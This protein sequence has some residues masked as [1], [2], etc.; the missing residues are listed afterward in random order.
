MRAVLFQVKE[1]AVRKLN[2]ILSYRYILFLILSAKH[3]YARAALAALRILPICFDSFSPRVLKML[4]SWIMLR[5]RISGEGGN[6][7]GGG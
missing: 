2:I 7:G 6:G 1:S 4:N 3:R 5:R